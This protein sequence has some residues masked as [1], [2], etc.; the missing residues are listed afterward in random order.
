MVDITAIKG[1][2]GWSGKLGL[3]LYQEV[4]WD[5][6]ARK[7]DVFVEDARI[8]TAQD[9]HSRGEFFDEGVWLEHTTSFPASGLKR[10][11]IK[12]YGGGDA[13]LSAFT[14]A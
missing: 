8:G 7:Q 10:V 9:F 2:Q 14:L 3:Y 5:T 12:R 4:D 6:P 1:P 13:G 11:R